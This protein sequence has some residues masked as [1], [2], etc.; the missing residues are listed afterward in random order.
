MRKI[1]ITGA[2]GFIGF[3]LADRLLSSPSGGP[4]SILGLD[5]LDDSYD[6][7]LKRER[8]A[9][10][11]RHA[12][13]AFRPLDIA[14]PEPLAALMRAQTPDLVVHLAARAGVRR[15]LDEPFAYASANVTGHLSVLEACRRMSRPPRLVYASSSS[16][17]RGTGLT[18]SVETDVSDRPASLYAATK[19]A[20]ELMSETYA[21]LFGLEQVG[22]RFFTVYGPFGRPDMACW[23]FTDKILK[24]EP[25]EVYGGGAHWRDFT[26][27]D[28]IVSGIL[29]VALTPLTLPAERPHAIYN[30]G[31]G[32]PVRL[33]AFIDLLEQAI[34]RPAIRQA[35]PMQPGDVEG[36]FADIGAIARDYGYQPQVPVEEGVRR[37]VRWFR[38]RY[39]GGVSAP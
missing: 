10:L 27:V 20:D 7:S 32:R 24:G 25:I 17:Y 36:T 30:L 13:F 19:R 38:A 6:V 37:F 33:S 29:S 21:G 35:L 26:Y 3:H 11:S 34:G 8:L 1:V 9:L 5:G 2:A 4:V 31:C 14:E 12:G 39:P 18:A 23:R 16:V 28:D 22:L 15:S